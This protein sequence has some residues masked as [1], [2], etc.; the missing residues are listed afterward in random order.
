MGPILKQIQRID[1]QGGSIVSLSIIII[2]RRDIRRCIG[3]MYQVNKIHNLSDLSLFKSLYPKRTTFSQERI[4]V[5]LLEMSYTNAIN[6]CRP[7]KNLTE[8][9][10]NCKCDINSFTLSKNHMLVQF[11]FLQHS[12]TWRANVLGLDFAWNIQWKYMAIMVEL[13]C[14][15]YYQRSR[16]TLPG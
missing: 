11:P 12:R 8:Y 16:T 15:K 14:R 3:S 13:A 1:S 2:W 6:A 5:N 10:V 7:L 4:C 9:A